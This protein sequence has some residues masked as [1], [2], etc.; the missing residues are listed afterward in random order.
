MNNPKK[1]KE[2]PLFSTLPDETPPFPSRKPLKLLNIL[3]LIGILFGLVISILGAAYNTTIENLTMLMSI[4]FSGIYSLLLFFS[5][6]YWVPFVTGENVV[7][8][9]TIF[10]VANTLFIIFIGKLNEQLVETSSSSVS[11]S[12]NFNLLTSIPWLVGIIL[13]FISVQKKYHFSWTIVLL[14]SGLYEFS[15]ETVQ[16]GILIPLLSG[17]SINFF[18]TVSDLLVL[19]F[20]QFVI[21][22]SPIYLVIFWALE[23]SPIPE[24]KKERS[25]WGAF[26]P[27][28]WLF[29]YS[30]YFLSLFFI[31][32]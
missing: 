29:P 7:K 3:V 13:I 22:H 14:L 11:M 10:A 26:K 5:R 25:G 19:D 15:V 27:L 16:N 1:S 30:I 6:K 28:L 32:S 18:N 23:D 31:F 2:E 8:N 24:G 21:L 4:L 9:T 12:S 20:W 17:Q